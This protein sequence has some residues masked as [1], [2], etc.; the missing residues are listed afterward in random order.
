MSSWCI[1]CLAYLLIELNAKLMLI[2]SEECDESYCEVL[3]RNTRWLIHKKQIRK[4]FCSCSVCV[5]VCV[6]ERERENWEIITTDYVCSV[7]MN[8]FRT[9]ISVKFSSAVTTDVI[10]PRRWSDSVIFP[11]LHVWFTY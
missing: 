4:F 11:L 1:L 5:C 9:L 10:K 2:L 8:H 7:N 6:G 3:R